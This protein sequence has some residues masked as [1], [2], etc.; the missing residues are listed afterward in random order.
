MAILK[1]KGYEGSAEVDM[2]RAV[3]YG[4]VLFVSDLVTYEA[5]SPANLK[6]EFEA[7]VDDYLETC[8]SLGRSPNKPLKGS[9]NVRT[10]PELHK[11][12]A[13]R[14]ATD[15]TSLNEVVV[16]ALKAYLST[17]HSIKNYNLTFAIHGSESPLTTAMSSASTSEKWEP[18]YVH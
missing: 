17:E 9:F 6:P 1:Y 18:L 8:A 13:L 12:A 3:C 14:A 16:S 2:S 11:D 4:R 7:A 15:N 10:P 5:D